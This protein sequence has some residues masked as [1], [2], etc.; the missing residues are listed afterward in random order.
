MMPTNQ[1]LRVAIN[2]PLNQLFDYLPPADCTNL[3]PGQRV[4][5]PFG[6][7]EQIGVIVELDVKSEVPADKLR[8]AIELV[9][10]EELL[11]DELLRLLEWS[12]SYYQHP[13]GEV[14]SA[15]LPAGLRKGAPPVRAKLYE[16]LAT[17]AA[18][19][20]DLDAL[21]RKASVQA[22]P[23][24]FRMNACRNPVCGNSMRTGTRSSRH[25]RTVAGSNV[26]STSTGRN[27]RRPTPLRNLPLHKVKH[28]MRYRR[29][30]SVRASCRA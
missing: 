28:W 15:A 12:A 1:V 23:P 14:I 3:Q 24:L 26:A 6:K 29:K 27:Q 5:V 13:P 21:A 8:M 22:K 7:R 10:T 2:T 11:D 17:D 20:V 30:D 25:S 18:K 16:W 19:S 9:D 4:R